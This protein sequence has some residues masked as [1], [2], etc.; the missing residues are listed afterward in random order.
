MRCKF[1]ALAA[2]QSCSKLTSLRLHSPRLEELCAPQCP[3]LTQLEVAGSNA[4]RPRDAQ[5]AHAGAAEP[6]ATARLK[7]VNLMGCRRMTCAKVHALLQGTAAL[8]RLNLSA[9][10]ALT[11]LVIPGALGRCCCLAA[12]G[13]AWRDVCMLHDAGVLHAALR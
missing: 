3:V 9:C 2:V 8:T 11:D 10:H 6:A 12:H 13:N 7:D 4:A 5:A 1:E